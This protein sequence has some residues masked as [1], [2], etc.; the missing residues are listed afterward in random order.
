MN[1]YI[2]HSKQ[3]TVDLAIS[4]CAKLKSHDVIFFVGGLGMGKTAF[5]QGLCMG[6]GISATVT[7]PTFAIVNEYLGT[8]LSLYHFDMYRIENEEQLYNIGFYDYL[9][10]DGIIAV[11]WSEN[12]SE[13][14]K[15]S[16][17]VISFEKL[18]DN[19]RKITV[20][21]GID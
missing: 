10:Y 6:L 17:I 19:T 15:D 2:T 13:F 3:E 16:T 1:N 18:D 8:P 7:S 20:S 12:I 4:L 5:C 9:D 21:G 11:E 14:F